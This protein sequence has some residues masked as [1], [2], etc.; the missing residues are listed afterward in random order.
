MLFEFEMKIEK[1]CY[2]L[3]KKTTGEKNKTHP[4]TEI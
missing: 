4:L 1:K 3:Q 2:L